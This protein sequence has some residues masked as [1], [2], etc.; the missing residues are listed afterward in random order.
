MAY[1][2]GYEHDIFISYAQVDNLPTNRGGKEIRWVSFFKDQ[3]QG[4]VNQALR[5]RDEVKVWM[6]LQDLGG[7]DPLTTTIDTAIRSTAALVVVLSKKY[8]SSPWCKTENQT[9]LKEAHDQK[10]LFVVR[11]AKIPLDDLPEGFRSVLG[12]EFFD[13]ITEAELDPSGEVFGTSMLNLRNKLAEMLEAMAAKNKANE[14]A[15]VAT[16]TTSMKIE[17]APA[18]PAVLLA[19]G[20]DDL[21][22]EREAIRTFVED[23]GYRVLPAVLYPRGAAEFQ[24]ALNQDL[25]QCKLFIQPLG[26]NGTRRTPDLPDGYEGLQWEQAKAANIPAVRAYERG[27]FDL[28]KVKNDSHRAFLG[29]NDVMALSLEEFKKAIKDK[30][31]YLALRAAKPGASEARD[32][33][34]LIH[35]R[36]DDLG[37]ARK[38]RDLLETQDVS[39]DIVDER[40]KHTLE[41]LFELK[42]YV[43]LVLVSGAKSE[44]IWI[45]E[46]TQK[47]RDLYGLADD[48]NKP[49]CGIYFDP[50]RKRRELL[51][52]P[53]KFFFMIDSKSPPS[54]CQQIVERLK[55]AAAQV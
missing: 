8:L 39:Y 55:A 50:P 10:R 12:F 13:P 42:K 19:E 49:P 35:T 46:R 3:L 18:K 34:V 47:L 54:E 24:K 21:D 4:R 14:M 29:A 28:A 26:Q 15:A 51:S 6:D 30:L 5:G 38:F 53:P 7:N 40:E 37:S 16:P 9:F 52:S 17:V 20:H 48:P 31:G 2:T 1:V 25:S 23:L 43:G 22:D 36:S 11:C 27:A 32:R 41:E 33:Q 45:K 44:D